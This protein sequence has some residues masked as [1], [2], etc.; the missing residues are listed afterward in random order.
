[1]GIRGHHA[2]IRIRCV[3]ARIG[4]ITASLVGCLLRRRRTSENADQ[5]TRYKDTLH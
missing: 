3:D 1:V 5:E 4:G 2:S